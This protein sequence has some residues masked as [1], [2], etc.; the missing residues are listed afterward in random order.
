[1]LSLQCPLLILGLLLSIL[2]PTN[3]QPLPPLFNPPLL[4]IVGI[5]PK[6]SK[7]HKTESKEISAVVVVVLVDLCSGNQK[8]QKY[9]K[10]D[11]LE[12]DPTNADEVD[13]DVQKGY[14]KIY[15]SVTLSSANPT[16]S[17]AASKPLS[18]DMD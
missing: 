2:P 16:I 6:H 9:L 12:Y 8:R 15:T 5:G 10:M 1:M 14:G 18:S 17:V 4:P 3:L 11:C 7:R 13:M